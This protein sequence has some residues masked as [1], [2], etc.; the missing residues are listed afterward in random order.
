MEQ[1][2]QATDS[3]VSRLIPQNEP[4][5]RRT[6]VKSLAALAGSAAL[7][8]YDIRQ[9]ASELPETTTIRIMNA[10]G[11]ICVAPQFV[12]QEMLRL[13]GFTDIRYVEVTEA[14]IRREETA[15]TQAGAEM[16]ARGGRISP[17][18]IRASW[19]SLWMQAYRSLF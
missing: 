4:R 18:S 19:P 15:N 2:Y 14:D 10:A 5:G 6:F 8:G 7:L 11:F 9:A 3:V 1:A 13:E 12:A 16:S 17:S